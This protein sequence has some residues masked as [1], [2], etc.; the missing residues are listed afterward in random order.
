MKKKKEK[1]TKKKEIKTSTIN[2]KEFW[3]SYDEFVKQR[4]KGKL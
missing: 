1:K 2:D 4:E 3:T